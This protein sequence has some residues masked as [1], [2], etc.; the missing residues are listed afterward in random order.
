M[1]YYEI[2]YE[3]DKKIK[4]VKGIIAGNTWNEAITT[5]V[6]YFGSFDTENG[7]GLISIEKLYPLEKVL[8]YNDIV[9]LF[10]KKSS[11]KLT[12]EELD[13]LLDCMA[14]GEAK[15]GDRDAYYNFIKKGGAV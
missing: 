10:D 4:K 2:D 12:T 5:L 15:I 3:E 1:F 13:Q 8:D 6:D 14:K 9:E 7:Y 11:D